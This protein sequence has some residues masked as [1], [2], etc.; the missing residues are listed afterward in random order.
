MITLEDCIG[1][2]GLTEEEVLAGLRYRQYLMAYRSFDTATGGRPGLKPGDR[3]L[4]ATHRDLARHVRVRSGLLL[5]SQPQ[6][7]RSGLNGGDKKPR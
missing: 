1:L 6:A 7:F 5:A 4:C 3:R 2:C